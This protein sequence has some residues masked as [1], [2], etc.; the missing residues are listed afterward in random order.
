MDGY[1]KLFERTG[2][3]VTVAAAPRLASFAA[4]SGVDPNRAC[5]PVRRTFARSLATEGSDIHCL[6]SIMGADPAAR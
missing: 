1:A 2:S 3:K 5:K 6:I 4:N